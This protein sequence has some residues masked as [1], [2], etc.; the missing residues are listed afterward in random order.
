MRLDSMLSLVDV[1]ICIASTYGKSLQLLQNVTNPSH[2]STLSRLFVQAS[3]KM[4]VIVLHIIQNLITIKMPDEAFTTGLQEVNGPKTEVTFTNRLA[5]VLF[6]FA[7][8]IRSGK[9]QSAYETESGLSDVLVHLTRT[10]SLSL[11][12][13]GKT[14]E[15]QNFL[16]RIE[17]LPEV[18][19]DVLFHILGA[20]HQQFVYQDRL[21]NVSENKLVIHKLSDRK[22][23]SSLVC[24][25]VS[26]QTILLSKPVIYSLIKTLCSDKAKII[27]KGKVLKLLS[28]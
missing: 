18:E 5:Q 19:S 10:I 25:E 7:V 14:E 1:F 27:L 3:P 13:T 22:P 15:L 28:L 12:Q 11:R 17:E 20:H 8:Q 21:L 26:Q 16:E 24:P 6:S 23:S 9:W 4:K 2:I